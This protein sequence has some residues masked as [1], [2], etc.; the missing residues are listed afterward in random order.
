M[1]AREDFARQGHEVE[2]LDVK[3]SREHMEAMLK[4]DSRRKVPVIVMEG[5]VTVGH[6]GT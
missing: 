4:H 5:Q 6:G 2:F 3:S 1:A